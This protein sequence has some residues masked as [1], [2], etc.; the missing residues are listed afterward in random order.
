MASSKPSWEHIEDRIET[1]LEEDIPRFEELI[2]Y[3]FKE[4]LCLVI[5][6]M[7]KRALTEYTMNSGRK[8]LKGTLIQSTIGKLDAFATLGDSI[9]NTIVCSSFFLQEDACTKHSMS[10]NK[11]KFSTN[12]RWEFLMKLYN[13]DKMIIVWPRESSVH[14]L[15]RSVMESICTVILQDCKEIA[16]VAKIV[17]KFI[18]PEDYPPEKYGSCRVE[19]NRIFSAMNIKYKFQD[20]KEEKAD[21]NRT[22]FTQDLLV[23]D[24]IVGV[25]IAESKESAQEAAAHDYIIGG[26]LANFLAIWRT[27]KL[28]TESSSKEKRH[29]ES[30]K[31]DYYTMLANFLRIPHPMLRKKVTVVPFVT[32]STN[33][34]NSNTTDSRLLC[35]LTLSNK[36]ISAFVS[37][38]KNDGIS[39]CLKRLYG[40]LVREESCTIA[41][42][43]EPI[44]NHVVVR[45]II[46]AA[47]SFAT[48]PANNWDGIDATALKEMIAKHKARANTNQGL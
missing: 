40:Y 6:L 9:I 13:L 5:A 37:S 12:T 34:Q 20:N 31:E 19:I 29:G 27:T 3:K 22:I 41:H 16:T 24:A 33:P 42:A 44:L 30:D 25:G 28:D 23:Q 26:G 4:P 48:T 38:G 43:H 47:G 10:V 21:N 15:L 18:A 45:S 14:P 8:Y 1:L 17:G 11:M 46:Q 39:G 2:G 36:V 7:S 35:Y 32:E